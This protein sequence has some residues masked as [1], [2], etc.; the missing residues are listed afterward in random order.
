MQGSRTGRSVAGRATVGHRAGPE[1]EARSGDGT[2][3]AELVPCSPPAP[4]LQ[5]SSGPPFLKF[6]F[7]YFF[8]SFCTEDETHEFA[9]ARQ[10]F[11]PLSS[12]PSPHKFGF[13]REHPTSAYSVSFSAFKVSAHLMFRKLYPMSLPMER[14]KARTGP[15]CL[16]R[17]QTLLRVHTGRN[18]HSG[19][20]PSALPQMGS[21]VLRGGH[22]CI[23]FLGHPEHCGN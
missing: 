2:R 16:G 18:S 10:A 20:S 5:V 14:R 1:V 17:Q 12:V 4:Q 13:K 21:H 9:L 23:C 15:T 19:P 22:H 3:G 7:F 11:A 6:N 8:Y